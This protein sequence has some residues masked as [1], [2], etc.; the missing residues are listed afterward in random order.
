MLGSS[1]RIMLRH[2][3]ELRKIEPGFAIYKYAPLGRRRK[4]SLE[5]GRRMCHG[6][7]IYK[8]WFVIFLSECNRSSVILATT[9]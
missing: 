2:W 1:A 4:W 9:G 7:Y 3:N 8:T 5:T 6:T